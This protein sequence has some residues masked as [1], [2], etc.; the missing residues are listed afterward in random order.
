M[1]R[2]QT[3]KGWLLFTQDDHAKLSAR[4]MSLWGGDGFFFPEPGDEL[5]FALSEH[6]CGWKKADGSPLLN[7]KGEPEDFTEVSPSR[8]CEI[9]RRSFSTHRTDHPEACV[10]IALHFNKFNERVLSRGPNK[11]SLSLKRE[12]GE[13][14]TKTLDTDSVEKVPQSAASNLK[15]LQTGDAI[16]LAL[17]HGWET[18]EAGGVPLENGGTA[19]VRL[20]AVGENNYSV[21]PWP[22][23]RRRCPVFETD[24]TRTLKKRFDSSEK[25][26]REIKNGRTE[27]MSFRLMPPGSR[28]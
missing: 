17:C 12:I 18:F 6:D 8:Q 25:L 26:R 5:L 9:W 13:F 1:I 7:S 27:K 20:K 23:S 15:L 3:D 16:S 4:I 10:L 19:T 2:R 22:F 11:W 14:V 24:F 28:G 21:S